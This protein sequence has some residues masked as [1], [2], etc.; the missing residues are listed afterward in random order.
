VVT[1]LFH[2]D[3]ET[4]GLANIAKLMVAFHSFANVPETF[5]PWWPPG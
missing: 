3:R 2:G 1:W 5:P 4:G